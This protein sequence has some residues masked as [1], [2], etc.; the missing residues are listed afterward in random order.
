[1]NVPHASTARVQEVQRTLIHAICELVETGLR[2]LRLSRQKRWRATADASRAPSPE[3]CRP[4]EEHAYPHRDDDR[5]HGAAAPRTHGV[6]R[7]VLEIDGEIVVSAVPDHRLPAHRHREDGRAEEVAAGDPARRADGL[8]RRA[9][10]QLRVRAVGR[11][12]A[13]PRDAGAREVD[14]RAARGTAADQQ[15]PRVARHARHGRRRRLGDA[16]L[17]PRA[18]ADPQHQRDDRRLP[19]VPELHPDRRPARGPAARV[20]RGG[21]RAPR[22]PARQDR[23]VRR[24][25]D[26]EHDLHEPH[27]GRRR[28]LA[29][30]VLPATGC[31]GPIAR[32]SGSTYDVRKA[33]PY[34]GYETFEFD[35]PTRHERRRLRPVPGA[36][37]GDAR[38]HQASAARR[39]T[40]ITPTGRCTR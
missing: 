24:P 16:L 36:G 39:S 19:D 25:A 1:M 22:P 31:V 17:L 29:G 32:A 9:V 28:L 11:E 2:W 4:E 10:E 20:P 30:A 33:F 13:R 26:E 15:P 14:P 37:R 21:Q 5:Q 6:L 40:R 23:R 3:P 8:P 27:A 18:R 7:L 35:V 38:E 12:A 34:C